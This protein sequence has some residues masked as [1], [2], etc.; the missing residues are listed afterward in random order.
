M[1]PA[2]RNGWIDL[3]RALGALG[4]VLFHLN[5]LP[6]G[7]PAGT[8]SAAWH[9]FWGYGHLGVG[10]FFF[11]S[12]YCLVPGWNRSAGLR[13][14][15]R[16]RL[17]R[18]MPPYWCSLLLV[19]ALAAAFKLAAGVNDVA[20]LPHTARAILATVLLGTTPVTDIPTMNWVY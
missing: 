19:V 3:L 1:N 8:V 10:V 14:F 12:G 15:L 17:G 18:I 5:A 9:W 6:T 20:L 2:P 7:R 4:V 13:D 16:R 11:L